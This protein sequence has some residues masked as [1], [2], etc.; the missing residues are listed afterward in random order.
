MQLPSPA[1]RQLRSAWQVQRAVIF[2][3]TARELR[4]R[5]GGQWLGLMWLVFEPLAHLLLILALF[6][7]VRNYSRG[8]VETPMFLVT[9]MLPFFVFRNL[10]LRVGDSIP[11]NRGLFSYRQVKPF[12]TMVARAI[13]E[14][15]LYTAVYL[16]VLAGLGWLGFHWLPVAPLE[17]LAVSLLLVGFGFG[18]ALLIA[19]ASLR[20]PK[21]RTFIG[22]LFVPLYLLSG[23]L[24]PIHSAPPDVQPWL[25]MNPVLHLIE[26]SRFYFLPNYHRLEEV[27]VFFV[28]MCTLSTL[29]FGL[30]LYRVERHRLRARD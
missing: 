3:L 11:A 8:D 16:V 6:T 4:A 23:V 27:S 28:L 29:F 9:G 5:V 13:V 2:A 25:L 17:L 1:Q 18:V 15:G 24:F 20:R 30:V 26:L 7:L 21:V 10:A 22:L 14:V 12:D 19:V